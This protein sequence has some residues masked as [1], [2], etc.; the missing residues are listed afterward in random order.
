MKLEPWKEKTTTADKR[1]VPMRK[2][3]LT[4][5]TKE[6]VLK[7]TFAVMRGRAQQRQQRF[8]PMWMRHIPVSYEDFKD[9]EENW[10]GFDY[11]LQNIG[12]DSDVKRRLIEG[13]TPWKNEEEQK[14]RCQQGYQEPQMKVPKIP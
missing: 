6:Q 3:P 12:L 8:K 14:R 7:S 10:P 2:D 1:I 5:M 9:K 4:K 11:A 13:K